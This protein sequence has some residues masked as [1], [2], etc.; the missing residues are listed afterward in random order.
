[1]PLLNTKSYE[2]SYNEFLSL[3]AKH[4]IKEHEL[5]FY[6]DKIGIS[7]RQLSK[8]TDRIASTTPKSIIDLKLITQAKLLLKNTNLSI[9]DISNQLGFKSQV[10]FCRLFK[11]VVGY[12][13]SEFRSM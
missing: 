8:I 7:T 12:T 9:F 6:A 3:V 5:A 10:T 2:A 4:Y 13:P 11:R 1:M